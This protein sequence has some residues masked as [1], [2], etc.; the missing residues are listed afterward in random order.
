MSAAF[1]PQVPQCHLSGAM[2][3][4]TE[5]T[6][7]QHI[8][9]GGEGHGERPAWAGGLR[10]L[11]AAQGS[12]SRRGWKRGV[13]K[14]SA[15]WASFLCQPQRCPHPQNYAGPLAPLTGPGPQEGLLLPP[16]SADHLGRAF[17][18]PGCVLPATAVPTARTP[19]CQHSERLARGQKRHLHPQETC[20]PLLC[21]MSTQH[22]KGRAPVVPSTPN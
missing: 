14:P 2:H 3:K 18:E 7:S 12:L 15:S 21:A 13:G 6:Q 8:S 20:Q 10:S 1:G 19:A 9:R 16:P 4:G 22:P 5:R 11:C 17:P